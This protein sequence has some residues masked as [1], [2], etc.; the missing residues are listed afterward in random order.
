[1]TPRSMLGIRIV[2]GMRTRLSH[3]FAAHGNHLTIYV[4][5]LIRRS[6]VRTIWSNKYYITLINASI[7]GAAVGPL[8]VVSSKIGASSVVLTD[9]S[10]GIAANI[11]WRMR[12]LCK[13]EKAWAIRLLLACSRC[14]VSGVGSNDLNAAMRSRQTMSVHLFLVLYKRFVISIKLELFR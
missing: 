6:L 12:R 10:N 13:A 1:M 7:V 2:T 3:L 8:L 4:I 14:D 5:S 9:R 11:L